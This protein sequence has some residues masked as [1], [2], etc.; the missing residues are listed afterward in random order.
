MRPDHWGLGALL[1][2]ISC[3]FSLRP[4]PGSNSVGSPGANPVVTPDEK[5]GTGPVVASA[6][7][8]NAAADCVSKMFPLTA[9]EA[10]ALKTWCLTAPAFEQLTL[11]FLDIAS[12]I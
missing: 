8:I 2:S 4:C 1:S 7:Q 3:R 11:T 12:R 9:L 6:E 10:F 5:S